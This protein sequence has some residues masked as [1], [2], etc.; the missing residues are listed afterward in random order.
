MNAAEA[1]IKVLEQA[2]V[3]YMFGIPGGAIDDFSNALYGNDKIKAIV[4]KHEAGAAYM[5]DAYARVT[6]KIG[7]CFSTAG[8]GASNLITGLAASYMDYIPVIALTGQ[9]ATSLFGKGAFQDSAEEGVNIVNIFRNFTKFSRMVVNPDRIHYTL[10]KMTRVACS[11]PKG[12]VHLSLPVNMMKKKI[13]EAIPR[14]AKIRER[15]FDREGIKEAAEILAAAEKPVILAGWGVSV[16]RGAEELLDFAQLLNIPVATSPKAK[17]IFPESHPLFLGVS[18]FAGSPVAKEYILK[19]GIDVLLAVG[20]G[21]N[22]MT[23]SGWDKKLSFVENLIH[24]DADSEKIGR[25]YYASTGIVGDAKTVLKELNFAVKRKSSVSLDEIFLKG[26]PAAHP[27]IGSIKAKHACEEPN[28]DSDLYH[29]RHL[30]T[31]IQNSFP[32]DTIFF[33]EIGNTMT[34]AIRHMVI[35]RPYSFFT[36]LGFGGMGYATAAPVGAKLGAEDRPVVGLVGDASFLMHGMEV[37]TAAEYDIPAIW[38]VFN[39]SPKDKYEMHILARG[40]AHNGTVSLNFSPDDEM[41]VIDAFADKILKMD[42]ESGEVLESFSEGT[43]TPADLD[44]A[45]DG[46]MYWMNPFAGQVYKKTTDGKTSLIAE[47]DTVIDGVSVNAEGRV[48]TA[49]FVA[50]EDALWEID[51]DGVL[52]PRV[53]TN[54]FGGFDA[55]DFGP[56]GYLYAPDYLYGSGQI[57][58]INID[59]GETEVVTDGFCSP[60]STK[61]NS[62]GELHVLDTGCPKAVRVDIVTGEKTLVANVDPGADNFDFNS[63]DEMFIAFNA[64][65]YIGKVLPDGTVSKITKPGIS[66]PGGIAIRPDGSLFVADG[67]ALRRCSAETGEIQESFYTSMGLIPPFS[68]YD[69]G[70]YLILTCNLFGGVQI[71]DPDAGESVMTYADFKTPLNAIRFMG[72][73]I[74][75]DMDT[76]NV[77]RAD[78]RM[79]LIEGLKAPAGLAAEGEDLWVGDMETGIIWKAVESGERLNPPLIVAEGL[80]SPEG[81]AVDNDGTLLAVEIGTRSLIRIDP[82]SGDTSLVADDLEI[83]LKASLGAAPTWVALSSVAVSESGDLYVTGDAGN[84]IYKLEKAKTD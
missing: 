70:T 24:I 62:R 8:P 71:W 53:V 72:D 66:S 75:A 17:G 33:A 65:S 81:I 84:I 7:V 32:K 79:P 27:D 64:D 68:L 43:E 22:E 15:L 4:T 60:I 49:S 39:D 83:G 78:D 46:T 56:D 80:A 40:A 21:L 9:V 13:S 47:L 26:T 29:P 30:I 42:P 6:G 37:A 14:P 35:D 31:D 34:W 69:D 28:A 41:F 48:F 67:F 1:I 73:I 61:F 44:F 54:D 20:T 18:G 25:N 59:T 82:D 74:V 3:E 52:P 76:G 5:A 12:P 77:V 36:S 50:G 16:S 63:E 57:F 11:N 58:K 45:P 55:F 2:E 19:G 23:A 38:I 10:H 51:P